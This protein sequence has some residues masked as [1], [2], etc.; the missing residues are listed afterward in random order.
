M[1]SHLLQDR[2][3]IST[4][5][6]IQLCL[7]QSWQQAKGHC[8]RPFSREWIL[9]G[10][11]SGGTAKS[12]PGQSLS[13]QRGRGEDGSLCIRLD[14]TRALLW[15]MN[16]QMFYEGQSARIWEHG[17]E[18]LLG[19]TGTLLW[20]EGWALQSISCPRYL[21]D[22]FTASLISFQRQTY[23]QNLSLGPPQLRKLRWNVKIVTWTS[24]CLLVL[25]NLAIGRAF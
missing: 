12:L 6:V 11:Q 23:R 18:S 2:V 14:K 15:S 20:W 1:S 4:A 25:D 22:S 3:G 21:V 5:P 24:N 9:V 19:T 8:R 7:L 16:L 10:G 13:A 17:L